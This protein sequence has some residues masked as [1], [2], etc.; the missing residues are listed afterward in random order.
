MSLADRRLYREKFAVGERRVQIDEQIR[1]ATSHSGWT[2]AVARELGVRMGFSTEDLDVLTR[3]AQLHDIGKVA[4]P[5]TLL[6]KG[7]ALTVAELDFLRRHVIIGE[8]LI[9]S[10]A[11][12]G[13]VARVVRATLERWDGSGYPDGL[14]GEE[15]PLAARIIAA[16]EAFQR[17]PTRDAEVL[18]ALRGTQLAPAV[19]DALRALLSEQPALADAARPLPI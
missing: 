16:C 12:L 10:R 8:R 18:Q 1:E 19:V 4:L 15:I 13:P 14:R 11:P 2:C 3:A 6:H 5:E 9:E 7:G 17:E